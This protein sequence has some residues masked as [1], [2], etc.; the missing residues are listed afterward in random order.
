MQSFLACTGLIWLRLLLLLNPFKGALVVATLSFYA[1]VLL[2][3]SASSAVIPSVISESSGS[4]SASVGED[5]ESRSSL[6]TCASLAV[7]P[8]SSS[9]IRVVATTTAVLCLLRL[10]QHRPPLPPPLTHS[11]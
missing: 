2:A 5:P 7:M 8:S 11:A 4:T 1:R 9:I 10:V 3:A 6:A